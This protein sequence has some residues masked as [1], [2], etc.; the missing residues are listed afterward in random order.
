MSHI[1]VSYSRRN[2]TFV[3]QLVKDLQQAG[4]AVWF[5]QISIQPGDIWEAAIEQ[6]LKEA[7][8]VV[9]VISPDSMASE[10]VRK[11]VNF[12]QE[13]DQ[14][15]LPVLYQ[16]A[17]LFLNLQTIQWVDLSSETVYP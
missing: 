15:I 5:D 1:F 3:T 10:Y 8:A 17:P 4:L 13:S 12:A 2:L 14:L 11:E 16:S 7:I 6:G 9:V